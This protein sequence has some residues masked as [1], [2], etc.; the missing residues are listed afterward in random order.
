[1]S[2]EDASAGRP[3]RDALRQHIGHPYITGQ[4]LQPPPQVPDERETAGEPKGR[5]HGKTCREK[6]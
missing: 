2:K 1:M 3:R 4:H 6:D 5:Q